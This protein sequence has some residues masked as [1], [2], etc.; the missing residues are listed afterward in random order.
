MVDRLSRP[1]VDTR[2]LAPEAEG[3]SPSAGE[4]AGSAGGGAGRTC[5][6]LLW[7]DA[8][9]GEAVNAAIE[10]A[11]GWRVAGV[12]RT[13]GRTR[14][15]L[16]VDREVV[17]PELFRE[18][19]EETAV[20]VDGD[21]IRAAISDGD[22]AAGLMRDYQAAAS[23]NILGSPSWVL[24]E[25]RQKL[26]GNIGYHVLNANVEGLFEGHTTDASWC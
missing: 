7:R 4:L 1:S 25:G 20:D 26:Y 15:G 21:G 5:A 19:I 22:A 11:L 13:F 2:A 3:T 12:H 8:P 18:I 24:N 10:L 16:H 6:A 9:H 23:A 14:F 17:V